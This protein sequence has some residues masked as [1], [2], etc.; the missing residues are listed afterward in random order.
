MWSFFVDNAEFFGVVIALMALFRPEAGKAF[1]FILGNVKFYKSSALI[2]IG[3]FDLG[4]SIGISGTVT[5]EICAHLIEEMSVG[6]TR[7]SDGATYD[8]KWGVFREMNFL[9]SADSKAGLAYPFDLKAGSSR[10]LNIQFHDVTTREKIKE[11]ILKLV[12][13]YKKFVNDNGIIISELS[14][15]E[16]QEQRN[17]FKQ[18]NTNNN[19]VTSTYTKITDEFYWKTDQYKGVLNI[20]TKRKMFKFNFKFSISQ[21]ESDHLKLNAVA[22]TE[23]AMMIET[24]PLFV[25]KDWEITS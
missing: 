15:Q 1:G 23:S 8:F 4:P 19:L 20:K 9:N 12:D 13:A 22:L 25:S 16:L 3:L 2:E 5:S 17:N 11:P 6:I 7:E 21:E 24:Q 14:L 18:I 10:N